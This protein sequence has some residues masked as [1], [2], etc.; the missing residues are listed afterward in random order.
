M[1]VIGCTE[2]GQ[3]STTA[4]CWSREESGRRETEARTRC[5]EGTAAGLW[6]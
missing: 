4:E 6:R 2:A 3:Q 5:S 1:V